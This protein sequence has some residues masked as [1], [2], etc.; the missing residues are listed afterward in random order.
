MTFLLHWLI[1]SVAVW[2]A[3]AVVPGF[4]LKH[5]VSAL[6]VAALFGVLNFF[7]GWLIFVV[8][9][10]ATVGVGFLLAFLTRWVVN[11]ILLKVTDAVLETLSI[12][13]FLPALLAAL[14]MSGVGTVGEWVLGVV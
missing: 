6:V 3:A 13:G 11:A 9:G 8:I 10:V 5:P 2:I 7:L 12:D 4:R 14:V 1:L